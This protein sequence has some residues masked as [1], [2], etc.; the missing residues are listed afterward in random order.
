MHL[1]KDL[2]I[3][4]VSDGCFAF[5]TNLDQHKWVVLCRVSVQVDC[6]LILCSGLINHKARCQ[7]SQALTV[8]LG[9]STSRLIQV[10]GNFQFLE[11]VKLKTSFSCWLLTR[12]LFQLLQIPSI[13]HVILSI[14]KSERRCQILLIASSLW[15]FLLFFLQP[16]T[17]LCF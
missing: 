10:T 4:L 2:S 3:Q 17:I 11:T 16:E 14:C 6:G 15:L 9:E 5:I 7:P 13:H 1:T 12:T 8:A